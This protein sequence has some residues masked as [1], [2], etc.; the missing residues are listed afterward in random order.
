MPSA[1]RKA[2]ERRDAGQQRGPGPLGRPEGVMS[3]PRS[4]RKANDLA[5]RAKNARSPSGARCP[6]TTASSRKPAR[7]VGYPGP[8]P[9]PCP[10]GLDP[11]DSRLASLALEFRDDARDAFASHPSDAK[12]ATLPSPLWGGSVSD[13]NDVEIAKRGRGTPGCAPAP[14]PSTDTLLTMTKTYTI[15]VTVSRY[16]FLVLR[17]ADPNA[18]GCDMTRVATGR[19]VCVHAAD[20]KFG[21]EIAP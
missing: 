1:R 6:A 21:P 15:T 4:G 8:I 3:G 17:F 7:S 10:H 20:S 16:I 2:S 14:A 9:R 19:I 12:R 18:R 11:G 13:R 5:F